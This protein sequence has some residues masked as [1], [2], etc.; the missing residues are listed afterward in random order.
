VVRR[1]TLLVL[2]LLAVA[3]APGAA[4]HAK[5]AAGWWG[6]DTPGYD[7]TFLVL[8][9]GGRSFV[10]DVSTRCGTLI[11]TADEDWTF[12]ASSRP[13]AA[14]IG[15][16]GEI[17]EGKRI[18]QFG[19]VTQRRI[20][21]GRLGSRAGFVRPPVFG[22][23]CTTPLR[24]SSRIAVRPLSAPP[25]PPISDGR[26]L[27]KGPAETQTELSFVVT[28]G[29]AQTSTMSGAIGG[30]LRAT[31]FG[32]L[33]CKSLGDV[34]SEAA[35]TADGSFAVAD[36]GRD[37][38]DTGKRL[39]GRF[40]DS[41][42][43][44]GTYT[45]QTTDDSRGFAQCLTGSWPWTAE[46][47]TPEPPP[48]GV[49]PVPARQLVWAALGDSYSS[50]E[51]VRPFFPGTEG[52]RNTCHR[53]R[54]AYSQVFRLPGYEF[55]RRD[56][57]ACSGAITDNVGRF[58]AAG[59][60][61]G[62]PQHDEPGIQLAQLSAAAWAQVDFVT[63]TIGGNDAGF[64]PVLTK[65]V[66]RRCHKGRLA[67]EIRRR[68]ADELPGKLRSTYASLRQLAPN[69]TVV[70]LGYPNLFP[71]ASD[72]R[73]SCDLKC[74]LSAGKREFIRELGE[75]VTGILRRETRAAG[76]LFTDP[77]HE[78]KGHEP[79][80]RKEEWV[81]AIVRGKLNELPEGLNPT[82]MTSFHPNRR[83]Q[84]AYADVLRDFLRCALTSSWPY[85][86]DTGLPNNPAPGAAGPA[87][88][89]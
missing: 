89:S 12:S 1:G 26:W 76:L 74:T 32:P 5:P 80:G 21:R 24:W 42:T 7:V 38:G 20:L 56:F 16:D 14:P 62:V 59:A 8:H 65:C 58:G 60:L 75:Q 63:I 35:V 85:R 47:V 51:G 78:F 33:P 54:D 81:N 17:A 3:V 48:A 9:S 23:G 49:L 72:F 2:V 37:P 25:R 64:G 87:G 82:S 19:L 77:R 61:E 66:F 46:L 68:L 55:A 73:R 41:A 71:A 31:P 44:A 6:G 4:A 27:L 52:R 88:C 11:A 69:A 28:G 39:E 67:R 79:C 57:L 13:A 34:V 22:T 40:G 30:H 43:A 29:G 86:P 84:Q 36:Q 83:G 15:R 18:D 70:V 45:L 50:G 53:S 10:Q